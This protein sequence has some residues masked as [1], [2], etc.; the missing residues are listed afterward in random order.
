MINLYKINFED[1]LIKNYYRSQ[2]IEVNAPRH[3]ANHFSHN[4][5]TIVTMMTRRRRF[6]V[7]FRGRGV[8][9]APVAGFSQ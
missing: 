5:V 1:K 9:L 7:A 2:F 3:I 8:R 6:G 4:Q